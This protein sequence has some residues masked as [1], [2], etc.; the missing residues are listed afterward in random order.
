M[1]WARTFLEDAKTWDISEMP[2]W[3]RQV[4]SDTTVGLEDLARRLGSNEVARALSQLR[5]SLVGALTGRGDYAFLL[6]RT[7]G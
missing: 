5:S 4:L 3:L 2:M 6:G 1:R 7:W